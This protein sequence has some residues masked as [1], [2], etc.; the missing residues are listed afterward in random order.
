M[1]SSK[2]QFSYPAHVTD[3]KEFLICQIN[4]IHRCAAT[5]IQQA[6]IHSPAVIQ[7]KRREIMERTRPLED[8]LVQLLSTSAWNIALSS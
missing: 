5:E 3:Y 2:L 8:A 6:R 1:S 4:E 7:A